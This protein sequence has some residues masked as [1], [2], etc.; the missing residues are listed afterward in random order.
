MRAIEATFK[1]GHI[2]PDGP[3]DWPEGCRLHI[4]PV[5]AQQPGEASM[6]DEPE[7]VEQIE[8]WLRWY[9][10]LEP[11]EF[12]PEEE[13]SLAAWRL[14]A[15]DYDHLKSQQRIEGLFP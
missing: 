15:K 12:T 13:A 1:N 9:H 5:T 3:P 10:A 11:L 2:V 14:K 8:D 4:E 6:S 7:T